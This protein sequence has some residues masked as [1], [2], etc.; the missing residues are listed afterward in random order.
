MPFGTEVGLSPSDIVL[1]S[2][3]ATPKGEQPSIFWR[4]GQMA[5]W[6]KMPLGMKGGLGPGDFVLDGD[7]APPQK[8]G[9]SPIQFTAHVYCGQMAGC[10]KMPLGTEVGLGPGDTVLDGDPAPPAK[11]R[12]Q[13]PIFGWCLLWLNYCWPLVIFTKLSLK[14]PIHTPK[15]DSW[16][17][18][19]LN[20]D[21]S[22]PRKAPPCVEAHRMTYWSSTSVHWYGMGMSRRIKYRK[23]TRSTN[24]SKCNKSRVCQDHPCCCSATCGHRCYIA[25][26]FKFH[27]NPLHSCCCSFLQSWPLCCSLFIKPRLH[28]TTCCQTGCQPVWQ[29]VKCLYTR[30]NRL[31]NPLSNRFDNWLDV[32]L[33]DTAGCQTGCIV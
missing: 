31:S 20:E 24:K 21:Q 16:G 1:G 12:G 2:D 23:E 28:D 10:I 15:M 33:H 32:C 25:M 17:Y 9:H 14:I 26:H 4:C 11:K 7:P 5:G 8:R 13:P 30:Y 18:D 22:D 6:I 19:P 3:R 27:Q 29:P